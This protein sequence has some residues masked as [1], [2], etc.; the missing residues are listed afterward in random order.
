MATCSASLRI[1]EIIT[2][3]DSNYNHYQYKIF[4][5]FIVDAEDKTDTAFDCWNRIDFSGED[6]FYDF[7]NEAKRRTIIMNDVDVKYGDK[8]LTLS[9]C[10]TI[11]GNDGP[12]RLIVLARMIREG[13]DPYEGTQ[14]SWVNN[15]IKW[16]SLYYTY[17]S[18][19]KYDPDAE[20]IPYGETVPEKTTKTEE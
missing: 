4:A 11:F 13:E 5:V 9:T 8:L 14:N 19:E 17:N 10:N 7:V 16:P 2:A 18:N 6:D 20:F 1:I 3:I 12:G 15:N